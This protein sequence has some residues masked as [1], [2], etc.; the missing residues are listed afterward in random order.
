MVKNSS[1]T[2]DL[3]FYGMLQQFVLILK[4]KND[5]FL[6]LPRDDPPKIYTQQKSILQYISCCLNNLCIYFR[7]PHSTS[8]N[9]KP[10]TFLMQE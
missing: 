10:F 7:I 8:F 5:I 1:R 2:R 6:Y 4:Q 9:R 3:I